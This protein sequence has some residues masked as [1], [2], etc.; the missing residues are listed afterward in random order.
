MPINASSLPLGAS[1][2]DRFVIEFLA[3]RGG[4]G[5]VY[6]ARDLRTGGAVALKILHAVGLREAAR[7]RFVRE[8]HKRSFFEC[9]DGIPTVECL[10]GQ[11]ARVRTFGPFLASLGFT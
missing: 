4:M 3:G 6:R 8:V 5:T 7:Q 9:L 2:A 10:S 11:R 1:V